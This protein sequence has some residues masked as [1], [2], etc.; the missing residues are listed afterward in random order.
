MWN[1][2]IQTY[3]K[4]GAEDGKADRCANPESPSLFTQQVYLSHIFHGVFGHIVV[5]LNL[6]L[7]ISKLNY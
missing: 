7:K 2:Q 4:K 1:V 3:C 5:P 6:V